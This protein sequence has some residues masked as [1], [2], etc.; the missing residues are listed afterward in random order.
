MSVHVQPMGKIPNFS[1]LLGNYL[2]LHWE[3]AHCT[4]IQ[5][6]PTGWWGTACSCSWKELTVQGHEGQSAGWWRLVCTVLERDIFMQTALR[7]AVDAV[8]PGW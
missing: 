4:G 8:W 2:Q 1:W 3:A 5:G 7:A 6:P